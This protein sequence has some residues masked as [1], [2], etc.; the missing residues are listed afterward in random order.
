MKTAEFEPGE[1]SLECKLITI[2]EIPW[3]EI[4]FT[5]VTFSLKKYIENLTSDSEQTYLGSYEI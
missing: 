2:D 4:A 5:S 3:Q 1:E